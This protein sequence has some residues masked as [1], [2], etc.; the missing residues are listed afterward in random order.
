MTITQPGTR[1]YRLYCEARQLGCRYPFLTARLVDM[2]LRGPDADPAREA[3]R[4]N[5]ISVMEGVLREV[6]LFE[7][8][9]ARE[10]Q[11]R[12]GRAAA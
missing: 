8:G 1:G 11:E 6:G 3:S 4:R 9:A 5:S 12:E 2:R 7:L 10:L